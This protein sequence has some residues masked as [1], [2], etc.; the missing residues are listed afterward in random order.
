MDYINIHP[1]CKFS[2][3]GYDASGSPSGVKKGTQNQFEVDTNDAFPDYPVYP[4]SE[5]IYSNYT[6]EEEVDIEQ[7]F[8]VKTTIDKLKSVPKENI[9]DNLNGN[10]LDI[11]GAELDDYEEYIGSE[12][13]ENNYYSLGGDNHENLDE[14]NGDNL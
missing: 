4:P 10:S 11:P 14:N 3:A 8:I 5:D 9:E 7:P 13:E 12:D 1:V 2:K 6:K